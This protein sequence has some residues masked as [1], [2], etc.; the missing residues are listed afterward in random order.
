MKNRKKRSSNAQTFDE[1]V[2]WKYVFL[3]IVCAVLLAA[4]FFFAALQHFASIELGIKN[5][6]LRKQIEELEAEKRRLLLAREV[7]L[8]PIDLTKTARRLGFTNFAAEIEE[9]DIAAL[10]KEETISP[11]RDVT[12]EA[13]LREPTPTRII[14]EP[15]DRIEKRPA[16]STPVSPAAPGKAPKQNEVRT[17]TS[18][19]RTGEPKPAEKPVRT[20]IAEPVKPPDPGLSRPR[21]VE[22]SSE[23]PTQNVTAVARL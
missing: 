6:E 18:S 21:R 2:E 20:V 14:N 1:G 8:S 16:A 5:S 9:I 10:R 4:G 3:T 13:T 17:T 22:S 11:A 12:Q 23:R 7:A 19:T 15:A